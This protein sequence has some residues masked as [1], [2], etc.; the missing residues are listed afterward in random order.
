MCVP[1]TTSRLLPTGKIVTDIADRGI[2]S[3]KGLRGERAAVKPSSS[4]HSSSRIRQA[5][6]S[7]SLFSRKLG[8]P[9]LPKGLDPLLGIRRSRD[10]SQGLRL[11]FQLAL[12]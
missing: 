4:R 1:Y 12:H 3:A 11:I 9:L 8:F 7:Q 10:G 2:N 6:Q 5:P